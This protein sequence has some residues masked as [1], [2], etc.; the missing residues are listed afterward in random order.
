MT[1][2]KPRKTT[3]LQ[4]GM[5]YESEIVPLRMVSPL[6][7]RSARLF[8]WVQAVSIA[9]FAQSYSISTIPGAA[10]PLQPVAAIDVAIHPGALAAG[11]GGE[12]YFEAANCIFQLARDGTITRIAG[13]GRATPTGDGGSALLAGVAPTSL[14][15]D[16]AG[17][18]YIAESSLHRIR[19]ISRDGRIVTIAG[20]GQRGFSGDGG[21]ATSAALSE[22]SAI[23]AD[24][25]GNIYVADTGNNR[26]RRVSADGTI[27]TIAGGPAQNGE[28]SGIHAITLD[29]GG[30][31]FVSDAGTRIRRIDPRGAVSTIA[32]TGTSGS[33]GDGVPA[34]RAE[35]TNVQSLAADSKGNL[36]LADYGSNRV[37][38]ISPDGIITTVAGTGARG[39]SGD[40]GPAKAAQLV[41]TVV[42]TDATGNLYITDEPDN[43]RI[44]KVTPDGI[45]R[46]VVG[47][48]DPGRRSFYGSVALNATPFGVAVDAAGTLFVA[49]TGYHRVRRI[50][51]DGSVSIIAGNGTPGNA[52]DGGPATA[53][54][55]AFPAAIALDVAGNL[56]ITD[57]DNNNVRRVSANGVINT[58]ASGFKAPAGLAVDNAGNVYVADSGNDRLCRITPQ[59]RM[60]IVAGAEAKLNHPVGVAIGTD[61]ALYISDYANL[62][63]KVA[64]Q[65]T[66][67]AFAGTGDQGFAGDDG[68]ASDARFRFPSGLAI[69]ADGSVFVADSLNNCV[70]RISPTG[71]INSVAGCGIATVGGF[72]IY[73]DY[74]DGG[75]ASQAR[76]MGPGSIAIDGA[77]KVY[78]ADV[79]DA[80]VRVLTPQ[81]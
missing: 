56:Y 36:Y 28:F 53:A 57:R 44:R 77:G 54:Q 64:P 69:G 72:P 51:R 45:I 67:S 20:T 6:Q 66:I 42:A 26:I 2:G 61:G 27:M 3:W 13:Y 41:P 49:D 31:L 37:R 17:N 47:N 68:P 33:A 1:T 50:S 73:A 11:P 19:R 39:F 40:G 59:G 62:I 34:I 14:A 52:G 12:L 23:A 76:L 46:T 29:S 74:G 78:V 7:L 4:P 22:P 70:R 24:K 48:G 63:R 18:L 75:P 38:R 25:T 16:P 35:L 10:P 9:C 32:G 55:L 5:W 60:N 80:A 65:G 81:R 43:N 8:L 79:Y 30:N 58:V 21:P 71:T 15:L